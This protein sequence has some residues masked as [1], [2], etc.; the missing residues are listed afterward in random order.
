MATHHKTSDILTEPHVSSPIENELP[1][2]RAISTRA[3]FS[4]VCGVISLLSIASPYFFIFAVL[5]VVLGFTADR[6]IQRY[7]DMLTGRGLAKGGVALGLIFGLGIFT[8]T[9]VQSVLRSRY[10][11]EFA[12]EYADVLK[13]KG[14]AELLWLQMPPSQR[15]GVSPSEVIEK[16][17]KTKRQE[18]AM[19][20]MKIK[21]LRELKSRLDSADDQEIHFVK[22]E[23]EGIDGVA[24]YAQALR[25]ARPEKQGI[26]GAGVRPGDL[27][28]HAR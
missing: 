7:P 27:Q 19:M 22:I 11:S 12:R 6:N 3:V 18:A 14:M 9:T 20:E 10:A 15:K 24:L 17:Q 25:T 26:S 8:I 13:H 21:D 4:L 2:Y 28:G 5:A 1:A 16:W 23:N